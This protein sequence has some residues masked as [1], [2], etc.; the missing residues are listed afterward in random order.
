M[1]N[2]RNVIEL[3]K[4]LGLKKIACNLSAVDSDHFDKLTHL[5]ET[6]FG[7]EVEITGSSG[8]ILKTL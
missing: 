7:F 1:R 8:T 2:L 6:K 5:Y 3:A 4:T